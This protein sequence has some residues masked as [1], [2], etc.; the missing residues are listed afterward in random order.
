MGKDDSG[1]NQ[2]QGQSANIL[3]QLYQETTPLRASLIQRG[4][5]FLTPTKTV[6][7]PFGGIK[8]LTNPKGYDYTQSPAWQPAKLAAERNY[9]NAR[10]DILG[11]LPSG[12]A[13]QEA[14]ARNAMSKAD[15]LTRTAG[16]IGLDELNRVSALAGGGYQSAAGLNALA[17]QQAAT[18]AQM[19]AANQSAKGDIGMGAGMILASK[20]G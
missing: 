11:N 13:L 14:L 20:A 3:N 1:S 19:Y 15:T 4:M 12:G 6:K 8:V 10:E 16:T 9:N 7:M 2:Y 18:N 5:D 17:G